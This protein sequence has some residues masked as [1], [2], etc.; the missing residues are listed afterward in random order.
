MFVSR[1]SSGC[2][3]ISGGRVSELSRSVVSVFVSI[4]EGLSSICS[5]SSVRVNESFSCVVSVGWVVHWSGVVLVVG[6]S[7]SGFFCCPLLCFCSPCL[8]VLCGFCG[9]DV[10]AGGSVGWVSDVTFRTVLGCSWVVLLVF[11]GTLPFLVS[12]LGGAGGKSR[13]SISL[14]GG[15]RVSGVSRFPE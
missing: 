1:G 4:S 5:I 14:P 8:F 12:S 6:L 9:G 10:G 2:C 13:C 15:G 3:S 11:V 7:M